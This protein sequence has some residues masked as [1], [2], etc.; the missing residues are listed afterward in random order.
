MNLNL[1]KGDNF[2]LNVRYYQITTHSRNREYYNRSFHSYENLKSYMNRLVL[3]NFLSVSIFP[4]SVN[5]IQMLRRTR[6]VSREVL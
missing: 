6:L 5:P 1:L 4:K 2:L 3:Y